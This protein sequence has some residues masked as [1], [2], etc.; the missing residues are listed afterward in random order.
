MLKSFFCEDMSVEYEFK[1][2]K[3]KG[4]IDRPKIK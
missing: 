2:G 1:S 3:F 4:G